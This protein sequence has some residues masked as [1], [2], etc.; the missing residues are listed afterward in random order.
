MGIYITMP[1]PRSPRP[2]TRFVVQ[3]DLPLATRLLAFCDANEGAARASVVRKAIKAYIDLR[4]AE[5]KPLHNRVNAALGR[6]EVTS[7]RL[8]DGEKP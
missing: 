2:S 7:M 1:R 8:V 4:L 3:L 6:N 5:D